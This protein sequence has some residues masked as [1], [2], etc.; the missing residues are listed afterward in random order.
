[1]PI[2]KELRWFYRRPA[3]FRARA[4][5]LARAG[6]RFTLLGEYLGGAK[7]ERC[8]R[9]DGEVYLN[10]VRGR[11]VVVQIGVAHLKHEP[12]VDE[13]DEDLAV[14]CRACHLRHDV[15]IHIVHARSTRQNRKDRARP[16]LARVSA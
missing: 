6:G 16:L 9:T 5:V 8:S 14:L 1:M 12:R 7:C 10:Y 13:P 11:I 4:R 15:P 2:R 3:W